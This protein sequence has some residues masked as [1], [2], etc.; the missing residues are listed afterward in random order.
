M[1]YNASMMTKLLERAIA[2]IRELPAEDQ[3][4]V[5]IAALSMIGEDTPLVRLDDDTRT[6][7]LE[8]LSQAERGEFVPDNIVAEADKRHDA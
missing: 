7:V 2:K 1:C 4:A 6:A 5:A 8:G 3:D